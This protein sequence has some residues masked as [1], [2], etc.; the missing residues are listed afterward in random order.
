MIIIRIVISNKKVQKVFEV[1][2]SPIEGEGII[3]GA[4]IFSLI[5]IGFEAFGCTYYGEY[6]HLSFYENL[7]SIS[8]KQIFTR[9]LIFGVSMLA[10]FVI[11]VFYN[12]TLN[13]SRRINEILDLTSKLSL[14]FNTEISHELFLQQLFHTGFDIIEEADY[15]FVSTYQ[16]DMAV[17]QDVIGHSVELIG[18]EFKPIVLENSNKIIKS[19]MTRQLLIKQSNAQQIE[20]I[21]K[22]LKTSSES[23]IIILSY[24]DARTACIVYQKRRGPFHAKTIEVLKILRNIPAAYFS[25]LNYYKQNQNIFRSIIN[26]IVKILSMHNPY[27]KEHSENV[28][29]L[30]MGLAVAL[31]L[32]SEQTKQIYYTGLVHD[33]G[34]ILIPR[35]IL[36]K[37]DKLT[38][39]EWD[40]I[41][42]HTNWGYETF[43]DDEY[44]SEMALSV[45]YHHERWDGLGYSGLEKKETPLCARIIAV[46]DAYE[47]MTSERSYRKAMTREDALTEITDNAGTQFDPEIAKIFVERAEE[48][49]TGKIYKD[50]FEL[51]EI[52]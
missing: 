37:K 18:F 1:E 27:T 5:L 48:I 28:A 25:Q 32:S 11:F 35:R 30:S 40:L 52:L 41:K 20:R 14:N 43:S 46:A 17:I 4:V 47:A 8:S 22:Y 10:G 23:L 51:N 16:G 21:N 15:G 44:L 39:E 24:K 36:D 33:I 29:K 19:T 7:F 50:I 6:N 13:Q 2:R 9:S 45:L 34:K 31:G 3:I 26:A 38:E 49:I 42:K 12:R